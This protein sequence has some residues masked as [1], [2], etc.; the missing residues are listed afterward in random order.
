M[1]QVSGNNSILS[2]VNALLNK[3]TSECVCPWLSGFKK[4]CDINALCKNVLPIFTS[5]SF[6]RSAVGFFDDVIFCD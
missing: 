4:V 1:S 2:D 6:L 3:T 5:D